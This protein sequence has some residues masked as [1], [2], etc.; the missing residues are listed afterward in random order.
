[1]S[2]MIK[3]KQAKNYGFTLIELLVVISIIAI[4]MAVLIPALGKAR[5]QAKSVICKSVLKNL[6][7]ALLIYTDENRNRMPYPDDNEDWEPL[8]ADT[9]MMNLGANKTVK[10]KE[11]RME[12]LRC[13]A[14][15]KTQGYHYAYN[16]RVRAWKIT[17]IQKP[18]E[19][20][21]FHDSYRP[22]SFQ[23]WV[24]PTHM[25]FPHIKRENEC[26]ITYADLHVESWSGDPYN[27]AEDKAFI[28]KQFGL[29]RP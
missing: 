14:R 1:M 13:P 15:K 6:G 4:L 5:S 20:I 23:P 12:L 19:R 29:W 18:K 11:I 16:A 10:R 28:S 21:V 17:E 8:F 27:N 2:K 7:T 25:A 3:N 24:D 9:L 22:I 26:N